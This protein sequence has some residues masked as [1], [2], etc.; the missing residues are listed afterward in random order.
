[1]SL[2]IG[3]VNACRVD[4][5]GLMTIPCIVAAMALTHVLSKPT[6]YVNVTLSLYHAMTKGQVTLMQRTV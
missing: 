3:G 1:M 5:S 2:S 4:K 6:L